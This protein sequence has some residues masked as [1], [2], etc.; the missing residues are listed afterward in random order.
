MPQREYRARQTGRQIQRLHQR[1]EAKGVQNVHLEETN[2]CERGIVNVAAE[3]AET[4][5]SAT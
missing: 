2:V 5:S 3:T 1:V 4:K